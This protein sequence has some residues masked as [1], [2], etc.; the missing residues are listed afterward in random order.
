MTWL[1]KYPPGIDGWEQVLAE[2][3][4]VDDVESTPHRLAEICLAT[5]PVL[6]RPSGLVLKGL[7]VGKPEKATIREAATELLAWAD[8]HPERP[9]SRVWRGLGLLQRLRYPQDPDEGDEGEPRRHCDDHR[10]AVNVAKEI[11]DVDLE[12]LS[13][14][15]LSRSQRLV[16][17]DG[18]SLDSAT[19]AAVILAIAGGGG[20]AAPAQLSLATHGAPWLMTETHARSVFAYRAHQRAG[21]AA[22]MLR[23]YDR[24]AS[25]RNAG[26]EAARPLTET[27]PSLLADALGQR[28]ALARALGDVRTAVD[29]LE[30]QRV[31][32]KGRPETSVQQVHLRSLG[33]NA[34]FFDDWAVHRAMR[35]E[36]ARLR[37]APVLTPNTAT[38]SPQEVVRAIDLLRVAGEDVALTGLGNDG[39]ELARNL[40]ESGRAGLDQG[41]RDEARLWLDVAELAWGEVALNGRV[42]IDFRRLELDALEG[43]AG[44]PRSVGR[45]MV[46]FSRPWRRAPG[47]RRAA[48]EAVRHGA[49]GDEQILNRLLE[50]RDAA[51]RVDAA[52]LDLG[53]ARWHLRAGDERHVHADGSGA[54]A[55]W[56]EALQRSQAA[57]D[58]LTI[59]RI[60]GPPVLLNPHYFVEALQ[61]QAGAMRRLRDGGTT[62]GSTAPDELA[63]RVRSLPAVAQRI[64]A[65]VTPQQRTVLDRLYSNWLVETVDLAAEVGDHDAADAVTEVARRDLVGSVL[66]AFAN[67]PNV[68][69][70]IADLA[71]RLT[72][73]LTATVSDTGDA[74]EHNRESGNEPEG[75]PGPLMRGVAILDQLDEALDVI[76]S[77]VGPVARSLF[78]PRAVLDATVGEALSRL[79]RDSRAAVLSLWL[80]DQAPKARLVRHLA[81][82]AADGG[83]VRVHLDAVEVPAWL[84]GLEV[85]TDPALF[86]ARVQRLTA[87]LLPAPLLDLLEECDPDHPLNLMIIPTGL[88]GVPFAALPVGNNDQLLLDLAVV[89]TAQSLRTVLTLADCAPAA[90][91]GREPV[92]IGVYDSDRLRHAAAEWRELKKSRPATKAAKSLSDILPH[93]ADPTGRGRLGILALAVHGTRGLDGWSQMQILPSGEHLTTGHVLQWYLPR[94]VVGAS[95]NTDIRA[96]AGGELGGFPLAFQ[97][98]GAS[99]IIGTLHYVEDEATA[100]IMGLLYEATAAGLEPAAALRQAQRQWISADRSRR[101]ADMERWAYLLTYGLPH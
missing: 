11:Q 97:L 14:L 40:I 27:H 19:R 35:L 57:A 78:D 7:P 89:S 58:G 20:S 34:H 22:R 96:D 38:P 31:Y 25:E 18:A 59:E 55:A 61:T 72:A 28:A 37:I 10:E 32:A 101:L 82:R 69:E 41:D 60:D 64:S 29:L 49:P 74:A 9:E 45:R 30:E 71:R 1:Y 5:D 52:F 17:E 44:D 79:G 99:T 50:L 66:S 91:G 12:V 21:I 77:V 75:D 62:A 8:G 84:L 83:D 13:L 39:Y 68:P 43:S 2:A 73:T 47:Q 6:T 98:R 48:I 92:E 67:E 23:D 51:P 76:G 93:V 88:L 100:Q 94:L 80:I 54:T 56:Q 95:C 65:A 63:V 16:H 3:T 87:H 4:A 42:A 24:A 70:Q 15:R 46:E 81:Y 86:F 33:A 90:A 53:V 36:R 85:G 26:I